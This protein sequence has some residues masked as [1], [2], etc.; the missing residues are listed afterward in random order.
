MALTLRWPSAT[1][2]FVTSS[3]AAAKDSLWTDSRPARLH[4]TSYLDGLRGL[5]ALV[6]VLCHYTE[7]NHDYFVPAFGMNKGASSSLLQLPFVRLVYAGR[8]MAHIFFVI[9]G[10]VLSYKPLKAVQAGDLE[11]CHAAIASS[12][13]RR[14]IRLFG[15]CVASTFVALVLTY[16][17]LLYDPLPNLFLQLKDWWHALFHEIT[18]AWS[19]DLNTHPAYDAH[20][21]VVP[22][23]FAHSMFLLMVI[24]VLAPLRR[25]VRTTV[26]GLIALYCLICG[27]WVAFE[28]L[29]GSLIA[30]AA[31]QRQEPYTRA[32]TT[33]LED[34]ETAAKRNMNAA[35][36][37][38]RPILKLVLS[39]ILILL[40]CF[41]ASWPNYNGERTPGFR[42]LHKLTPSSVVSIGADDLAPQRFWFGL[43][44]LGLVW[45]I[46]Q[47]D[48]LQKPLE[49]RVCQYLGRISYALY[50]V[51]G[52]MLNMVQGLIIGRAGV[53]S[54]GARGHAGYRAAVAGAGLK[55]IIGTGS[56]TQQLIVWALGIITMGPFIMCTADLF[57][58]V[59]DGPVMA[60]ARRF[61]A[62]CLE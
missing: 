45:A 48:G 3:I 1:P 38:D 35:T 22:V 52:P 7:D 51:H 2:T 24:T 40:W 25:A 12:A 54:F 62:W 26:L 10:L 11:R 20:L 33:K 31:L 6:V 17:G 18:W 16:I 30:D 36:A 21:W 32:G 57:S 56:P 9:S 47:L 60:A 4:K 37:K 15:P 46:A 59:V 41:I 23:E 44:A 8:P 27:R 50:L 61:E 29:G 55:G 39:G 14:P 19:W 5:A 58:K 42:L 43:S 13:L 49:S 53:A 34:E 28:F